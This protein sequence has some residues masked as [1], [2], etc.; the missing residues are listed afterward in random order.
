MRPAYWLAAWLAVVNLAAFFLCRADKR[1][2]QAHRWRISEATLLWLAALGGEL[3]LGL[4]MQLYRHKTK[5]L[6]FVL[7]VPGFLLLHLTLA[8]FLLRT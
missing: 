8:Y 2:A 1:R 6:R 4:G 3:G 5:H 7:A